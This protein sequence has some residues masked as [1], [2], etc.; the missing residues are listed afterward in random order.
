[1]AESIPFRFLTFGEITQVHRDGRLAGHIVDHGAR[2]RWY[3]FAAEEK[4][5][6]RRDGGP[7]R[8][9]LVPG[10]PLARR[11]GADVTDLIGDPHALAAFFGRDER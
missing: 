4:V 1:M 2:G 8:V 11:D 9:R 7:P 6:R 3:F 5:R 10:G